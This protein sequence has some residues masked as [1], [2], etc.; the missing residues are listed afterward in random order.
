MVPDC[1]IVPPNEADATLVLVLLLV[2]ILLFI[3]VA[4][5]YVAL[6]TSGA[7]PQLTNLDDLVDV[8]TYYVSI[9]EVG[10]IDVT[11]KVP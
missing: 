9:E 7:L 10:R 4:A 2:L 11:S 3:V 1:S 6:L 8:I 5:V